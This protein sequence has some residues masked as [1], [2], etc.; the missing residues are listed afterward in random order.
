MKTS[1]MS[2]INLPIHFSYKLGLIDKSSAGGNANSFTHFKLARY[3]PNDMKSKKK[4]SVQNRRAHT[5]ENHNEVNSSI[6][7]Y[8]KS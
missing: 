7:T 2:I 8:Q 5:L 3:K 1:S 6:L 4:N